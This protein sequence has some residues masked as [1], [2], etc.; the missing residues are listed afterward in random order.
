MSELQDTLEIIGPIFSH[1]TLIEAEK[2]CI[3]SHTVK[4]ERIKVEISFSQFPAKLFLVKNVTE[5]S[6]YFKT[7]LQKAY[8][9]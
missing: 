4:K 9:L 7:I 2:E 1:F 5:S 8:E 3:H 6:I